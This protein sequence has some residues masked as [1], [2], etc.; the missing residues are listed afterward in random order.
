MRPCS[1][2]AC[3]VYSYGLVLCEMLTN[4]VP[5]RGLHD[6]AIINRVGWKGERPDLADWPTAAAVAVGWVAGP[7]RPTDAAAAGWMA[8]PDRPTDAAAA[9]AAGWMGWMDHVNVAT[10]ATA[11]AAA[12]AA[13]APAAAAAA[14]AA[15]STH[16]T[17]REAEDEAAATA[18]WLTY[19]PGV[20]ETLYAS[21]S[22][23][24]H[25]C[26]AQAGLAAPPFFRLS[27]SPPLSG[28]GE[29]SGGQGRS[30]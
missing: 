14:A 29:V 25:A 2:A 3:D 20:P 4:T 27:T 11:A 26:W 1:A 17:L 23:L 15:K 13:A 12:A 10:D 24:V 16:E 28:S 21:L 30:G 18:M 5:F 19:P 8:G 6:F 7:D 22:G 9:A